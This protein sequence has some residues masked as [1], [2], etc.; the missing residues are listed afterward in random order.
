MRKMIKDAKDAG[1]QF[2]ICSPA[3]DLWGN[4]LIPEI[5]EPWRSLRH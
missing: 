2:K 4:N 1:V 3:L 5:K